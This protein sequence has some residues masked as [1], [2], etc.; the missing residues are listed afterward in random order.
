MKTITAKLGITA[1]II[2]L[3]TLVTLSAHATKSA[4]RH[5][6]TQPR[7]ESITVVPGNYG[8]ALNNL[9]GR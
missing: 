3:V 8:E 6:H 7:T 1:V 5:H 2:G 4:A 9:F